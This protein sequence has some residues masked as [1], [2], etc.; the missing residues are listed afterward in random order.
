MA[1]M[2][3][4]TS[5]GVHHKVRLPPQQRTTQAEAQPHTQ[6]TDPLAGG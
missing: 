4:N 6:R 1:I 2:P 3:H 5:L